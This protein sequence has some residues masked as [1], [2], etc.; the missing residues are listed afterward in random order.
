MTNYLVL[1]YSFY[2]EIDVHF[3]DTKEEL[4]EAFSVKNI[5]QLVNKNHDIVVYEVNNIWECDK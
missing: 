1:D 2:M 4:L 5:E 3:Y